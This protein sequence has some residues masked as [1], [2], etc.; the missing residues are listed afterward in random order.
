M[1]NRPASAFKAGTGWSGRPGVGGIMGGGVGR[2]PPDFRCPA[3][4][5]AVFDAP[6]FLF[7]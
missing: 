1:G 3:N 2:A 4:R 6:A 5:L 7:N